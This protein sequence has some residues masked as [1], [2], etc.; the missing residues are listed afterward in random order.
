MRDVGG[1]RKGR[2]NRYCVV[3]ARGR[4]ETK[5]VN[6]EDGAIPGLLRG[7]FVMADAVP[8]LS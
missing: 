4:I 1:K 8:A 7:R 6:V 5:D 2:D 3:F